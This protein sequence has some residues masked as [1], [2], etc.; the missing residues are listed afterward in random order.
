QQRFTALRIAGIIIGIVGTAVL[1]F[2][3]GSEENSGNAFYGFLVV[4][5]TIMYG[6]SLNIIKHK[7]AGLSALSM[8]SLA[9]LCVGPFAFMYLFSTSAFAKLADTPGSWEALGYIAL[10]A[11]F[12]TA[13]GLVLYNKLIHMTT[14]LFASSAT[15]LMPIVALLWGILDGETIHLYHYI[16][17]II[18]LA[19]VFIVNRAK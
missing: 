18:I 17:M 11:G 6:G 13:I 12:S 5:A 7:L 15:Y 2:S 9:L 10:L 4:L 8:A 14:T 16:G 1:I 3:G 19:G